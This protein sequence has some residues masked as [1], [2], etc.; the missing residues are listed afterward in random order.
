MA[1]FPNYNVC[2]EDLNFGF[3]YQHKAYKNFNNPRNDVISNAVLLIIRTD[4]SE[5]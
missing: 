1:G 2:R 3:N 5:S 4:G